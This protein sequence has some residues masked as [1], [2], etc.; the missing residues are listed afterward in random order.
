MDCNRVVFYIFFRNYRK[1]L[2]NPSPNPLYII[3]SAFRDVPV[4]KPTGDYMQQD[5]L[6]IHKM[7]N[8][9]EAAMETFVRRYYAQILQYCGYHCTNRAWAEDLTQDTF[10]HFFRKLADYK[11]RGKALNYLYTIARNLCIDWE[12]KNRESAVGEP[13]EEKEA[14]ADKSRMA[15]EKLL[16]ETALARLPAE[17]R[18]V[19]VLHFFQ[20][21]SLRETAGILQIGLP[22]VKYRLKK[23]KEQL[24]EFLEEEE[25][26]KTLYACG[27]DG[28]SLKGREE[29]Y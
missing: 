24:R 6:L 26:T 9:D 28:G 4:P 25:G 7:K 17:L 23:A 22:L 10:E 29:L 8:G 27:S 5:F 2:S 18:E 1:R 19:V 15:V 12:R 3:E 16:I 21:R 13:V 14:Y 20:E 11:H